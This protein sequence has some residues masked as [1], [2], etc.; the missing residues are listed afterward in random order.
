VTT[1]VIVV[2]ALGIASNTIVFTI[3]DAIVLSDLPYR[4]ANRLVTLS[5]SRDGETPQDDIGVPTVLD[6]TARS[7]SIE[8]F[9]MW[10][11]GGMRITLD[12]RTELVRGMRVSANYFDLLG[13]AMQLGRGFVSAD[14]TPAG[15]NA[16]ILTDGV[17]RTLF[18]ADPQIVGR[19]VPSVDG[20]YRVVGVL[21][22]DFRPL[23]MSNPGEFPR[24]FA[25]L[26]LDLTDY[27]CRSC[28][29]IRV[30]GRMRGGVSAASAQAELNAIL[31]QLTREH[32]DDYSR[33]SSVH[34]TTLRDQLVGR[35]GTAVAAAQAA[36]A[37]FLLL[38][39]ANVAA[40]LLA[41]SARR[42]TD[43]ALRA[44]L[45]ASRARIVGELL[46]ESVLLA[47]CGGAAGVALASIGTRAVVAFGASEIPRLQEV[48]PNA[49]M[50]LFGIATSVATGV[51]FGM[52][53]A[54]RA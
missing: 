38:A 42:R 2:M 47:A 18:G 20:P 4:D 9:T 37:L 23:H 7:R 52:L 16:I 44:A 54:I 11:D 17:W 15:R 41:Q 45:G 24:T 30:V 49:S 32:P 28:A 50:L 33:S 3:L 19:V 13:V 25:P 26:G 12:G 6:W 5:T 46:T 36:A 8:S 43:I 40:L 51:V 48:A 22:A 34:V 31:G 21:P 53:P 35:F 1:V 29:D 14:D 10:R 27:T 39:C